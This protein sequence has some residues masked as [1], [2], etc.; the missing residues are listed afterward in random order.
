MSLRLTK[1]GQLFLDLQAYSANAIAIDPAVA[2]SRLLGALGVQGSQIPDS[3]EERATLWRGML[4][5]RRVLVV[6]DNALNYDQVEPL[7]PGASESL[8]LITSRNRMVGR[9]KMPSLPLTA[10]RADEAVALFTKIV[11]PDRLTLQDDDAVARVVA[12]CG[13]LPLAVELAANQL[14][15]HSTWSVSDLA[16]NLAGSFRAD[17]ANVVE[18]VL[19]LSYKNLV[20][21]LKRAFRFL[22]LHPGLIITPEDVAALADCQLSHAVQKLEDLYRIHLIEELPYGA[23]R[24]RIHDLVRDYAILLTNQADSEAEQADAF[25]R[26]LDAYLSYTDTVDECLRCLNHKPVTVSYRPREGLRLKSFGEALTWMDERYPNVIA[27]ASRAQD[28]G[29]I[30]HAWRIPE[31]LAY[32]LRIRGHLPEASDIHNGALDAAREHA[33]LPGEAAA[34]YNLGIIDRVTGDADGARARLGEALQAYRDLGDRLRQAEALRALGVLDRLTGDYLD[35][36]EHLDLALALH[37]AQGNRPGQAWVLGAQGILNRLT[38][39]FISARDCFSDALKILSETGDKLGEAWMLN[40]LGSLDRL[41]GCYGDAR[42]LLSR[43]IELFLDLGDQFSLAWAVCQIA[44][45]DRL[46]GAHVDA[47]KGFDY[48][49]GIVRNL[50]NQFAEARILCELGVLDRLD[51]EYLTARSRLDDARN[52]YRAIGDSLGEAWARCELAV[53]D[54]MIRDYANA[55]GRLSGGLA[56]YRD[57][58]DRLGEAWTLNALGV[59]DRLTGNFPN[60]QSGMDQMLAAYRNLSNPLGEAW[61]LSTLG[62]LGRITGDYQG[63]RSNLQRALEVHDR[64][65]NRP[66]KAWTLGTLGVVDM[67]TLDY[68]AARD[69]LQSAA[70]MYHHLGNR[71]GEAWTLRELAAL[72]R[73]TGRY[74][75]AGARL[76]GILRIYTDIHDRLGT[77]E[78]LVEIGELRIRDKDLSGARALWEQAINELKEIGLVA[79]AS[80]LRHRFL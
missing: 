49:L 26:L 4:R 43:A 10:F 39:W 22:G 72:D 75:D 11:G 54:A 66:G 7:L 47:R 76:D 56:V 29:L 3:L 60:D 5:G 33:D 58:G 50:G 62:V 45:I 63:A 16:N 41:T 61:T 21:D 6:L 9:G 27:C 17:N 42:A 70:T 19:E 14:V 51:G 24:Y 73:E 74:D 34:L 2:L 38:G 69:R 79:D 35:A 65:G 40:E 71:L 15:M 64:L 32:F 36:K 68:P 67:M 13:H 28:L 20:P 53:L 57:L 25:S 78:T 77:A 31:M 59:V 8:V 23:H 18:A 30:P 37:L 80:Y 46:T 44:V 52:I 12:R 48:A 1:D 55:T